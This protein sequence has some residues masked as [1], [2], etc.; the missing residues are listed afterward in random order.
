MGRRQKQLAYGERSASNVHPP[1]HFTVQQTGATPH[2]AAV[3]SS[4]AQPTLLWDLQQSPSQG[5]QSAGQ[6]TQLSP[7]SQMPSPQG[8]QGPQSASQADSPQAS[9]GQQTPSPQGAQ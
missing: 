5:P 7:G 1:V 2:T 3:T 6:L 9:P 8:W 4:E